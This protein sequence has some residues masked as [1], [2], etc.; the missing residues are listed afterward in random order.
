VRLPL[1]ILALLAAG[2]CAAG[3]AAA[4]PPKGGTYRGDFVQIWLANDGRSISSRS[5]VR[6]ANGC[7][8][9]R[10]TFHADRGTAVAG[11]GSFAFGPVHGRFSRDR[12]SVSGTVGPDCGAA[13]PMFSA[14]RV[15]PARGCD[16]AID[17]RGDWWLET[18]ERGTGCTAAQRIADRWAASPRCLTR[19]LAARPCSAARRRCRPARGG[20]LTRFATVTCT[21]G[22][23]R[24]E[25]VLLQLCFDDG[26]SIA[27][28]VNFRCVGARPTIDRWYRTCRRR[29]C[30]IGEWRCTQRRGEFAAGCVSARRRHLEIV[31]H[32]LSD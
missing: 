5:Y 24:V 2:A 27:A 14:R 7:G 4:A 13:T 16:A 22:G 25:L 11:D 18:L 15:G 8:G 6:A 1:A 26:G 29:A 23:S 10:F 3:P 12:R 31:F 17:L 21:R 19:A 9:A 28:Y 32:S 30:R 20:R